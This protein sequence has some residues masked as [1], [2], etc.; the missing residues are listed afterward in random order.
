MKN[1]IFLSKKCSFESI[2]NHTA[3][4]SRFISFD[5]SI[6]LITKYLSLEYFKLLKSGYK[7]DI[8]S[9]L[10][11]KE[12]K[13]KNLLVCKFEDKTEYTHHSISL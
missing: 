4:L 7:F 3:K 6:N 13:S 1:S 5:N 11:V 10:L 8:K 2:I 12:S 9:T